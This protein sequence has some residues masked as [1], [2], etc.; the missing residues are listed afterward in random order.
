MAL[1]PV[2]TYDGVPHRVGTL[3]VREVESLEVTLGCRYVEITPL[4]NMRH[5]LAM[6]A[7]FLG[8][9]RSEA[10]VEQIIS[11]IDLRSVDEMWDLQEDDL[12]DSYEDG[13]PNR[14]GEP[15]TVT[16]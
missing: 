14:G 12:P 9:D 6:M 3:K 5:K 11:D 16:S 2:F 8:R 4:G 1:R 13:I 7:I 15:S 10:E